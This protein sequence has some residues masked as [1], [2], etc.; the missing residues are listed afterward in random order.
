MTIVEPRITVGQAAHNILSK[1]Q[2]SQDV[3][4]TQREMLKGYHDQLIKCVEANKDWTDPFYVCVQTRRERTMSNVVRNQFY[5]R[6]TRPAP[7]YDL[8][9]YYYNPKVEQLSFVW[10]IP[11]HASVEYICA[12]ATTLPLDQADLI[13][14]C[15]SFKAGTL[16]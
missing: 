8:A 12:N 7:T 4:E 13:G 2:H 3:I 5:A 10:C 9:L 14:F 6:Q 11:D 15:K 16:I 1:P